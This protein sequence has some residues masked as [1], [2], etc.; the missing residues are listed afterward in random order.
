MFDMWHSVPARARTCTSAACVVGFKM[1]VLADAHCFCMLSP[2]AFAPAVN[3]EMLS[4]PPAVQGPEYVPPGPGYE[5]GSS[6]EPSGNQPGAVNDAAA[7]AATVSTSLCGACILVLTRMNGFLLQRQSCRTMHARRS[8]WKR[9]RKTPHAG[10]LRTSSVPLPAS[11]C[12]AAACAGPCTM[13][14]LH[15]QPLCIKS[16]ATC[17]G[18]SRRGACC[19]CPRLF[20]FCHHKCCRLQHYALQNLCV[21]P[22]A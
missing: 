13:R 21:D 20:C 9:C 15:P 10:R 17:H 5:A 8:T 18:C 3:F 7:A 1:L 2:C 14:Q 16:V 6:Y 11:R 19:T 12:D 22:T 4:Y